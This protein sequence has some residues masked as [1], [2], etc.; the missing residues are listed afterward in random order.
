MHACIV[1][2]KIASYFVILYEL[3]LSK[4]K[5]CPG[6]LWMICIVVNVTKLF[7]MILLYA[8]QDNMNQ[9]FKA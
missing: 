6:T 1:F 4:P 5:Q 3:L 8:T 7:S 2:C 9:M